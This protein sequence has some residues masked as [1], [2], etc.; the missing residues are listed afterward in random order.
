MFGWRSRATARISLRNRSRLTG[1]GH[2]LRAYDLE[3]I[4][5]I[6]EA[7]AGEV[8]NTHPAGTQ[9]PDDRVVG[10]VGE[11]GAEEEGRRSGG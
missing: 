10:M 3:D 9:L 2:D 8:H 5:A 6:Q 1:F 7:I 11:P 4:V